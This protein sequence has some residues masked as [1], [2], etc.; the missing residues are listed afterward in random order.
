MMTKTT[1]PEPM[2][3]I[4]NVSC[5]MGLSRVNSAAGKIAGAAARVAGTDASLG[6]GVVLCLVLIIGSGG[7]SGKVFDSL[8]SAK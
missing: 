6:S 4:N 3:K 5:R 8:W 7:G 1:Q 2:V